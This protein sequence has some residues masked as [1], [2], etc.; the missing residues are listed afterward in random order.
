MD[1][2]SQWEDY[3]IGVEEDF[4][5]AAENYWEFTEVFPRIALSV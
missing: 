3:A 1:N 5:V 4:I 2:W